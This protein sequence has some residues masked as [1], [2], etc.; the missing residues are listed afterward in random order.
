MLSGITESRLRVNEKL[1]LFPIKVVIKLID[2]V[3]DNPFYVAILKTFG[4]EDGDQCVIT[5]KSDGVLMVEN[6]SRPKPVRMAK[7]EDE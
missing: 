5:Q 4:I 1:I 2:V 6:L 7:T 3:K